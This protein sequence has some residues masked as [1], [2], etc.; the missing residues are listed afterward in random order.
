MIKMN[1]I[2]IFNRKNNLR[3]IFGERELVIIKKQLLGVQLSPSEKT[4]LSRDIR[5]KLNAVNEISRFSSD[6]EL[7]KGL[8][9]KRI[10]EEAKEIILENKM[11]SRIKKIFLFG[12]VAENKLTLDSDIDIA[13]ELANASKEDSNKFR[14]EVMGKVNERVDFKIYNLLPKKIKDEILSKG[15]ILYEKKN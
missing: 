8:E 15:R 11:F 10:I 7:K 12:S 1:I 13:A 3:K 4:R 14:K 6:F 2:D 5:K 9:I